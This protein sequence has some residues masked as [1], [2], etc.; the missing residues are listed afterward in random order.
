[1]TIISSAVVLVSKAEY[2]INVSVRVVIEELPVHHPFLGSERCRWLVAMHELFSTKSGHPSCAYWR[3]VGH[4]R[5][6]FV[7]LPTNGNTIL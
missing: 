1:M 5:V 7:E 2:I 3:V 4:G 6:A